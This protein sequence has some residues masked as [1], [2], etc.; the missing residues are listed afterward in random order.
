MRF[1][2]FTVTPGQHPSLFN[3]PPSAIRT[4]NIASIS[5]WQSSCRTTRGWGKLCVLPKS[6]NAVSGCCLM[7]TVTHMVCG[8]VSPA[9]AA[10]K[11][12]STSTVSASSNTS[13]ASS[14]AASSLSMRK[15]VFYLHLCPAS[16]RSS[17]L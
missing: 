11:I 17:Q 3:L 12:S 13:S 6:T 8:V 1:C 7:Y 15:M 9:R 10:T 14:S 2:N 16:R 5:T 4:S